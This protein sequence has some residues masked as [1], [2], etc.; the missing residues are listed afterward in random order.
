MVRHCCGDKDCADDLEINAETAERIQRDLDA[1]SRTAVGGHFVTCSESGDKVP[2]FPREADF[3]VAN[4]IGSALIETAKHSPDLVRDA[5]SAYACGVRRSDKLFVLVD[6]KHARLG[7][8]LIDIVR[9]LHL[10]TLR[11][12]IVGFKKDNT[13][14]PLPRTVPMEWCTLLGIP[15]NTRVSWVSPK[16]KKN[17]ASASQIAIEVVELCGRSP[18]VSSNFHSVMLVAAVVLFPD[19]IKQSLGK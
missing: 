5:V 3:Q 8:T 10:K 2:P 7:R 18:G 17:A 12:R 13:P 14:R 19:S 16:N 15:S 6:S 11:W 9:A 1:L 4:A